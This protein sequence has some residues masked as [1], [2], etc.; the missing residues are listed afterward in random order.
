MKKLLIFGLIVLALCACDNGKKQLK[1]AEDRLA[2][3][4]VLVAGNNLNA[5]KVELDSLHLL[6]PKQVAVRRLAQHLEDSIALL[7]A[8]RNKH[9]ADSLLEPLLPETDKQ[10]KRFNHEKNGEYEDHGRYVH[11]LLT[12]G[13]NDSR[14]FLQTYVTDDFRVT[15]K[16]YYYGAAS[17][18]QNEIELT[19]AGHTAKAGGENHAFQQEG[20]H[21]ILTVKEEDAL[22]LLQFIDAQAEE[23]IKVSLHGKRDYNYYLSES[24]KK[25]L[26]ETR[27]L[28][29]LMK[30]VHRLEEMSNLSE[31]QIE[32]YSEKLK[33]KSE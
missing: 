22:N 2:K 17:L 5:A 9:Y 4:Q 25:A 32:Y 19:A 6:Y 31:R 30:D 7:E 27:S 29:V 15:L 24:E 12:T 26:V 14:C 1:A 13:R 3:A 10:V 21:E 8:T 16:S 33:V 23:K 20:W 11:K 28:A 18:E